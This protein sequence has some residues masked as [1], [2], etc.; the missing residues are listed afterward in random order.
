[1]QFAQALLEGSM[2]GARLGQ[3]LLAARCQDEPPRA[4]VVGIGLAQDVAAPDHVVDDLGRALG[5]QMQAAG[6]LGGGEWL[7]G[8]RPED[9]AEGGA[10][11]GEAVLAQVGVE[12]ID[13]GL[14][15]QAEQD[16]E[17]V[18]SLT[19]ASAGA[20]SGMCDPPPPYRETFSPTTYVRVYVTSTCG[21]ATAT[22]P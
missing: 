2:E 17:I 6:Q 14:V 19:V 8:E 10:E 20:A 5:C 1:V 7:D 22:V 21:V 15:G 16:A 3:R 9:V 11:V 4:A 18:A 13:E 12:G